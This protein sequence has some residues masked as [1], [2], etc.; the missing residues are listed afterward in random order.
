MH[1]TGGNGAVS[2]LL[3]TSCNLIGV[4]TVPLMLEWLADLQ[5]TGG[6]DVEELII[7]LLYS[8]F[9]PCVIGQLVRH[10]VGVARRFADRFGFQLKIVSSVALACLPWMSVSRAR[11]DGTLSGVSVQGVFA[12]IG[13]FFVV[14]TVFIAVNIIGTRLLRVSH[15]T[16]IS[17]IVMAS[18]KT[19]PVAATIIS[20]LPGDVG[21]QGLMTVACILC[22]QS[23]LF[24]DSIA[25][26]KYAMSL[27]TKH[28]SDDDDSDGATISTTIHTTSDPDILSS[29]DTKPSEAE[30]CQGGEK[31][32]RRVTECTP[33]VPKV[34][35][36][37]TLETPQPA[38]FAAGILFR[39]TS[40][41]HHQT[42][43]V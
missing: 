18:Q 1:C 24:Y 30:D 6:V 34:D 27:R 15:P 40:T 35:A 36:V 19:F 16:A 32:D 8:L 39:S 29:V 21:D 11:D 38:Q 43:V 5:G 28:A 10:R 7:K 14:H 25:A 4:F 37:V 23:Q 41:M 26:A 20:F 12:V 31:Q 9:L 13:Y 2:L 17:V 33:L 22:Q 42:S 3:T